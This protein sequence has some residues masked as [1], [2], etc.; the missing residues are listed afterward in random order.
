MIDATTATLTH[1]ERLR[2]V[3]RSCDVCGRLR[4]ANEIHHDLRLD[5]VLCR[6]GDSCSRERLANR[7]RLASR[8]RR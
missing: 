3:W 7:S 4:A 2:L 8:V 6:D 1:R 5:L